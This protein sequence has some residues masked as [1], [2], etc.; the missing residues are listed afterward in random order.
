MTVQL[1]EAATLRQA[2]VA[3]LRKEGLITSERVAAAMNAVPRHAFA[4]DEPLE[5]VYRT[6]TT[7]VPKLDADGRQ[8]S[9]VSASHI[10]AAEL[11]QAGVWPGMSVL[12]IGSGGYNA[13]LIAEVVGESGSVTT[14]D[15]D[16]DIVERARTGL[17]RAGYGQVNVVLADA[18]H[19]VPENAPYDRII[20]TVGAWDIP[21]AWLDQ[22]T[23]GGRIVV[24]L[25]FSAVTRM[26]AFDRYVDVPELRASSYRLGSFVPMQGDGAAHESLIAITP[27]VGLRVDQNSALIFDVSA[28]RK[29]LNASPVESWSG[30]P[31]DMP[32]ELELFLLTSG[33][34]LPML[35]ASHEAVDQE[36]VNRTVRNG[37]PALVRGGTIA[38]R[39][40]RENPETESGY[41]TGVVAHGPEAEQV[42]SELLAMIRTWAGSYYRRNAATITYHPGTADPA[43]PAGWHTT[44]RHGVLAVAWS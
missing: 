17:A 26:I 36:V 35:H 38:Y 23:P 40:K 18:E 16:P 2:M 31:F 41:E 14:V 28:L 3:A 34:E 39:I 19:G 22:L 15:I 12:E 7:L 27:D 42:G 29:A 44:K 11:E 37:T 8:T 5:K 1:D 32:D 24:P 43:S 25:R 20:V 9:V 4:P 6:D 30:T 21:P 33:A 13:A 10:Q